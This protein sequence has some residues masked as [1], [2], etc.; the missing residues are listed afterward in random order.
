MMD[1]YARIREENAAKRKAVPPEDAKEDDWCV[2]YVAFLAPKFGADQ[3]HMYKWGRWLR[4]RKQP[5]WTAKDM[6][7]RAREIA[8][9]QHS[10]PMSHQETCNFCCKEGQGWDDNEYY[11]IREFYEVAIMPSN[12]HTSDSDATAATARAELIAAC[13]RMKA[14]RDRKRMTKRIGRRRSRRWRSGTGKRWRN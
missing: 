1:E 12:V 4:F 11:R 7:K 2:A 8:L 6:K 9:A 10:P 13:A 14:E 3:E 5:G